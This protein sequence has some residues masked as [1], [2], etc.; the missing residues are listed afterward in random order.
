[1]L[2]NLSVRFTTLLTV[3]CSGLGRLAAFLL[4][5]LIVPPLTA[6][7]STMTG[8]LEASPSGPADSVKSETTQTADAVVEAAFVQAEPSWSVVSFRALAPIAIV[9]FTRGNRILRL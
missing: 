2:A 5:M 9:E 6:P 7:F 3:R 4:I 1:L 8:E